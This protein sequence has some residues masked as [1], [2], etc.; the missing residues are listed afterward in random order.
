M[1]SKLSM[2]SNQNENV[3]G[4]MLEFFCTGLC[5][6]EWNLLKSVF[7]LRFRKIRLQDDTSKTDL[8]EKF[9]T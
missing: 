6:I 7:E 1:F 8:W 4:E 5:L 3:D 2:G 9:V